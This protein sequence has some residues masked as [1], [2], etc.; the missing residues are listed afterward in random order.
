MAQ[1]RGTNCT[2]A[3]R[4]KSGC[5]CDNCV[6]DDS[7]TNRAVASSGGSRRRRNPPRRAHEP[8]QR[9]GYHRPKGAPAKPQA[10]WGEEEQGSV[11]S[12]RR[13]AKTEESGLCDDEVVSKCALREKEKRPGCPKRLHNTSS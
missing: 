3:H 12:F 11:R 4:C 6:D 2:P 7:R 5:A 1:G 9:E 8:D 10:L 13:L